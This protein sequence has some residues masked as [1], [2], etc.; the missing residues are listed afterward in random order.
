MSKLLAHVMP[1]FG[2]GHIH[3]QVSYLSNDP[4]VID[5]QIQIMRFSKINNHPILG[6]TVTWMGPFDAFQH[7]ATME[8]SRQCAAKNFLFAL[9]LNPWINGTATQT[10]QSTANVLAALHHADTATMLNSAGYVPEK[11]ILEFSVPLTSGVGGGTPDWTT[12]QNQFPTWTFLHQSDG[13]SWPSVDMAV[14]NPWSRAASSVANLQGQNAHANMRIPGFMPRFNDSGMPTPSG[15]SLANWTGT[16]DYN[17]TV[18]GPSGNT[19]RVIEDNAG[20][21][22]LDQIAVTPANAPYQGLITW[23]D[24]DEGT[25]M[26]PFFVMQTGIRIGS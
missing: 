23:N 20:K 13:F 12:I 6:V 11:F 4:A 25:A 7:S 1:W 26:E 16:R 22:L 8:W 18:W 15:V 24:Y 2:D 14:T 21:Y 19:N 5:R 17:T 3:R 10:A 9:L